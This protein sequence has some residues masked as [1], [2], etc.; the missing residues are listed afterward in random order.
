MTDY[1]IR[2]TLLNVIVLWMVAT[3][4]FFA[5]RVLPG[6]YAVNQFAASNIGAVTPEVIAQAEAELGLDKPVLQ[7]YREFMWDTVRLDLG[8]SFRSKRPVWAEIRRALPYSMELGLLVVLVGCHTRGD[9]ECCE[10]G[11]MAGL[12]PTRC[13]NR[14]PG[15][16]GVLDGLACCHRCTEI[17]PVPH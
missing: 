7:Q 2:R 8:D 9:R 6:N 1:I 3:L 11:P 10:T 16:T 12:P 14:R 5:L 15:C 13:G 17:Q 4:V